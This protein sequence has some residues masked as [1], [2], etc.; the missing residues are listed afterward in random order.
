M[1]FYLNQTRNANTLYAVDTDGTIKLIIREDNSQVYSIDT[2]PCE[3]WADQIESLLGKTKE[4]DRSKFL[5]LARTSI[6]IL[7]LDVERNITLDITVR[8]PQKTA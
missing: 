8:T 3:R 6:E 4:L 1:N 5:E 7:M 2:D